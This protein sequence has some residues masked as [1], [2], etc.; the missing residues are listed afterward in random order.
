MENQESQ[1]Y[2]SILAS[3]YIAAAFYGLSAIEG[4]DTLIMTKD[5]EIMIKEI[6]DKSLEII[7]HYI[8][9][10]H[11]ETFMDPDDSESDDD[12]VI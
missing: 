6:K 2:E 4:I 10:Y 5:E 7:H 11:E 3:E 8:C 12:L 1:E 9:L